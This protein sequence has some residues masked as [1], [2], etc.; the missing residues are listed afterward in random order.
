MTEYNPPLSDMSFLLNKVFN[1]SALW[2]GIPALSETVDIE[3]AE[4]ILEE[5]GKLA[6]GM[7]AP[8]NRSGDEEGAQWNDGVVTT[9]AGFKEAYNTFAEGGWSGLCGDPAYGGMGMPKMLGVLFDEMMY[10]ANSSFALYP[11]LSS[12]ACLALNAHGSDELK[13]KYL[14]GKYIVLGTDFQNLS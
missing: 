14:P 4:A 5:A 7:I 11:A 3:T 8:L 13:E 12:G 6:S 1:V 9:P 2:Q 10:A